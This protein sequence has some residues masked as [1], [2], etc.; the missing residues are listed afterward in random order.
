MFVKC[1]Q[2]ANVDVTAPAVATVIPKLHQELLRKMFHARVNEY[3]TASIEI[4]LERSG[5]VVQVEQ[6]LRDQL[7][8]FSGLKTR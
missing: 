1:I 8:T 7:K 6:S 2:E 3:M 4:D 5:K